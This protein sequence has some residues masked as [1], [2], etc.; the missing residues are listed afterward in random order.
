MASIKVRSKAIQTKAD[1]FQNYAKNI[2]Q[3]MEDATASINELKWAWM[4]EAAKATVKR[5]EE[6]EDDFAAIKSTIM[7]YS[8]LLAQ[9]AA[10]YRKVELTNLE[11]AQGKRKL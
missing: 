11:Q 7:S 1:N 5:F 3:L 8:N 10:E 6:L 9:A 2:N 4:G